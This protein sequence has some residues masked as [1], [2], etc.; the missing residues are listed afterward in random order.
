MGNSLKVTTNLPGAKTAKER[1]RNDPETLIYRCW[2]SGFRRPNSG[3]QSAR[4]HLDRW[5]ASRERPK[6]RMR[7]ACPS[8][9]RCRPAAPRAPRGAAPAQLACAACPAQ[10]SWRAHARCVRRV[11][12][13]RWPNRKAPCVR[14]F[15]PVNQAPALFIRAH[16]AFR[17]PESTFRVPK[18]T[19]KP[20][21]SPETPAD[22]VFCVRFSRRQT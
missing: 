13:S 3:V 6:L 16:Y 2:N 1:A 18:S 7:A 14:R 9:R 15:D 11:S 20:H 19:R 8:Q 5:R 4:I 12:R 17:A 22:S 21:Y 10:V